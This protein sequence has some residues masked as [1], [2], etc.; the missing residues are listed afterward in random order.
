[1]TYKHNEILTRIKRCKDEKGYTNL[2]LSEL[3][4]VSLGTLNKILSGETANPQL[5]AI[6]AIAH[7]L[8]VSVDYLVYGKQKSVSSSEKENYLIELWRSAPA[9]VQ[10]AVIVLLQSQA[11]NDDTREIKQSGVG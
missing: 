3:S 7:T 9:N 6:I 1:M 10:D 5:P 2:E 11:A 4:G 8:D